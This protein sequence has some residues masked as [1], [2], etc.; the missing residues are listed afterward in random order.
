MV[1]PPPTLI[2]ISNFFNFVILLA[3][4]AYFIR[5]S[6]KRCRMS[7]GRLWWPSRPRLSQGCVVRA[8]KA[9][10]SRHVRPPLTHLTGIELNFSHQFPLITLLPWSHQYTYINTL[11]WQPQAIFVRII[12][13]GVNH[14]SNKYL[15]LFKGTFPW[16]LSQG[17]TNYTYRLTPTAITPSKIACGWNVSVLM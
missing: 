7:S 5:E 1:F 4:P 15:E 16:L 14:K 8:R 3:A 12:A 2:G 11:T 6:L 17:S 10:R 9:V 13:V